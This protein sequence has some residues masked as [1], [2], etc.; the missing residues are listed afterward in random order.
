VLQADPIGTGSSKAQKS[1]GPDG[2]NLVECLSLALDQVF[3]T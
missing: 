2:R 3:T 1:E